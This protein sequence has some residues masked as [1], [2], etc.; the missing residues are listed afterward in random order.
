MGMIQSKIMVYVLLL[1]LAGGLG[2]MV[3]FHSRMPDK[4]ATHFKTDG[5]PDGWTSSRAFVRDMAVAQIAV[6]ALLLGAAYAMLYVPMRFMNIPR[7]DYWADS[8]REDETRRYLFR[9]MLWF[10]CATLALLD[11]L[12]FLILRVN[13]RPDQST[14][15]WPL[16]V[17]G[18][19]LAWVL[20]W[21]VRM[22]L[23]FRRVP[24]EAAID[25]A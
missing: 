10:G 18:V 16:V 21:T 22:I 2:Q 6:A 4:M 15:Y 19:F 8:E 20:G 3:V 23:R 1:L 13:L 11:V 7:K 25:E 14:G 9:D 5:R 12:T 17:V 24:K